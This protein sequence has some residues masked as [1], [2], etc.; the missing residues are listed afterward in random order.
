[1]KTTRHP[2][3]YP[4]ILA[5]PEADR[6]RKP[7]ERVKYLSRHARRAL[8][9]SA[10]KSGVVVGDLVKDKHG[11]PVP[12]AGNFWSLTHKPAYVGAVI[13]TKQVGIDIEKIRACSPALFKKVATDG[14]WNLINEDAD[15]LFFRYW[16]AKEATLKATGVGIRDLSKCRIVQIVDAEHLIVDYQDKAWIVE[17][18]FFNGHIA[19]VVT[20][21]MDVEWILLP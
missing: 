4:V 14:E 20:C 2:I 13:A 3:I 18:F 9:I 17:H 5:V 15:K 8:E 19:S 16:T 6:H 1:M 21:D 10:K 7:R 11:A 12:F